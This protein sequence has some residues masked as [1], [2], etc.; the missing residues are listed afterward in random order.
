MSEVDSAEERLSGLTLSGVAYPVGAFALTPLQSG[1]L[2]HQI[3]AGEA[4]QGADLEQLVCRIYH[5]MAA[6]SAYTPIRVT[7]HSD[8]FGK[9][10]LLLQFRSLMQQDDWCLH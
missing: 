9:A 2:F 6:R 1:M 7:D 5:L 8:C 4:Q 3:Q 10:I